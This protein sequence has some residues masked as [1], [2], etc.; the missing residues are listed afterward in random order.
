MSWVN[1]QLRDLAPAGR[2]SRDKAVAAFEFVS[3]YAWA[4]EVQ[5]RED[6]LATPMHGEGKR[7]WTYL[8]HR[9]ACAAS[10]PE[11]DRLRPFLTF[12]SEAARPATFTD[13]P[14]LAKCR[15]RSN[16]AHWFAGID[17]LLK[18]GSPMAVPVVERG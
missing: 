9:G 11:D 17:S 18:S 12:T 13:L 1:E 5:G 7:Y 3:L 16:L 8:T 4:M 15:V 10:D 6:S 14:I 2:A